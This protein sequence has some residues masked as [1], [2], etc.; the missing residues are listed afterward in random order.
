MLVVLKVET[1][2]ARLYKTLLGRESQAKGARIKLEDK[3][4]AVL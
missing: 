1:A 2:L 3:N 4:P